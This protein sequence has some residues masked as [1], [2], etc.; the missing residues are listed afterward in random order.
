MDKFTP[1]PWEVHISSRHG[2][3]IICAG[4]HFAA[5]IAEIPKYLDDDLIAA[6]ARL[7]AAAPELHA[8]LRVLV[9]MCEEANPGAWNNGVE[10]NGIQEGDYLAGNAIEAARAALAK[11]EGK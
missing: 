3:Q 2:A 8:A 7:I 4:D 11:V 6:N 10:S 5:P 1:G 9:Q